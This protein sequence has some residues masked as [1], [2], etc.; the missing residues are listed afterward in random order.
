M[1]DTPR[2]A[3][4][5]GVLARRI[6][7]EVVL[8]PLNSKSAAPGRKAA[9]LFVLNE[10]GE[11]LWEWL[12]GSADAERLARNLIEEFEVTEEVAREDVQAFLDAMFGIGAIEQVEKR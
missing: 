12:D 8:I 4:A 9:D 3:R 11:R 6:A 5:P 10:T 7:G 2:Y 1:T